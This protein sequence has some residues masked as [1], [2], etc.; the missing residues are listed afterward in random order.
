M[1]RDEVALRF[2]GDDLDSKLAALWAAGAADQGHVAAL[3]AAAAAGDVP[4]I[5]VGGRCAVGEKG[6]RQGAG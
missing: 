4:A 6:G 2:A 5:Q 1:S 3:C